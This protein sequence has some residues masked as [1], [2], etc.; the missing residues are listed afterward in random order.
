MTEFLK[1]ITKQ[2]IRNSLAMAIVA[3]CFWFMFKLLN[4]TIPQA[5]KDTVNLLGGMLFSGFS[6]VVGYYFGTS[7]TETDAKKPDGN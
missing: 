6:A 4:N 1:R 7:K 2:D 5:N 3:L